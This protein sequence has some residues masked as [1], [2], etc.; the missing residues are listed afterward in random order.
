MS[1]FRKVDMSTAAGPRPQMSEPHRIRVFV[2]RGTADAHELAEYSVP[3][4]GLSVTDILHYIYDHIDA[5]LG[6][7]T[8]CRIGLCASCF[9]KVN[10]K[11]VLACRTLVEDGMVIEAFKSDSMI[12]D[13]LSDLPPAV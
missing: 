8:S 11:V 2:S 4:A 12:R 7:D 10:G 9:S 3:S 1:R 13:L 6:F 5:T